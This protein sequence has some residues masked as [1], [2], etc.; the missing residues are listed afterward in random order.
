M[1]RR[2]DCPKHCHPRAVILECLN[3]LCGQSLPCSLE[4]LKPSFE[5][6]EGGFGDGGRGRGCDGLEDTLGG[7]H[8]IAVSAIPW[9]DGWME[10]VGESAT[11]TQTCRQDDSPDSISRYHPNNEFLA[12]ARRILEGLHAELGGLDA[13][14]CMVEDREAS[15]PGMP[16]VLLHSCIYNAASER[17]AM[18]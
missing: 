17:T 11:Q 12:R 4:V 10:E 1:R 3:G 6:D 16:V 18:S 9:M 8:S 2:R 5:L 15:P 14:W 7:L 13:V